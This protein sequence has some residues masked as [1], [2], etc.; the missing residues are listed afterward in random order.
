MYRRQ[1]L[2]RWPGWKSVMMLKW[3]NH[4]NVT[5]ANRRYFIENKTNKATKNET[6]VIVIC[7]IKTKI[8]FTA[9]I[10]SSRELTWMIRFIRVV[11]R[12]IQ[13][14]LP[15]DDRP[16]LAQL[17][18]L[19]VCLLPPHGLSAVPQFYSR[20]ARFVTDAQWLRLWWFCH[21]FDSCSTSTIHR[22]LFERQFPIRYQD[23]KLL[24]RVTTMKVV[25]W[26][27]E[28]SLL[29]WKTTGLTWDKFSDRKV[30]PI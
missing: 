14:I 4:R 13:I 9:M 23:W 16:P 2:G 21:C 12:S 1:N 6:C 17:V 28:Q 24:R 19:D 7:K 22:V 3:C 20:S 30:C 29:G 25:R 27:L 10:S 11:P 15:F 8:Y 5:E 18:T 26:V